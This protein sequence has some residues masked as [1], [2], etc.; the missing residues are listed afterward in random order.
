M[1]EERSP[2]KTV[3]LRKGGRPEPIPDAS[4]AKGI[5]EVIFDD[6][7]GDPSG[8]EPAAHPPKKGS[9]GDKGTRPEKRKRHPPHVIFWPE[10]NTLWTWATV[11]PHPRLLEVFGWIL[12]E[13]KKGA[14]S[15]VTVLQYYRVPTGK[16]RGPHTQTP[17]RAIDFTVGGLEETHASNF[18]Q[19]VNA[20]WL[21]G[22]KREGSGKPPQ[23]IRYRKDEKGKHFH[24]EVTDD[25]HPVNES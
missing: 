8:S 20:H 3:I 9:P 13:L 21:H 1:H 2:R 15:S 12:E 10:D 25:T 7:R 5:G 4:A 22:G 17:C 23:V 14:F 19:K 6:T 16:R 24:L 11:P 18:A